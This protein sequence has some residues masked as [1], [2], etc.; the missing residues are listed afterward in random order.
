M[1]TG[2]AVNYPWVKVHYKRNVANQVVLYG[3]HDHNPSTAPIQNMT[4]GFPVIL[5]TSEGMQGAAMR[6]IEI[7]AVKRP[8]QTVAAATY[9]ED[10]TFTFNGTQF[11]VSGRDW[12]PDTGLPLVGGTEVN[13]IRNHRG[14]E[15]HRQR[16]SRQPNQQRRRRGAGTLGPTSPVNL[17]SAGAG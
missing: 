6:R 4:Q 16:A 17:D 8:Y 13:G 2:E 12:D 7:E 5:A 11:L 10:D 1:Q 9:S 3:D 14:P 15:Q